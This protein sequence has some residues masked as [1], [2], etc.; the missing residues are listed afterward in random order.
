MGRPLKISKYALNAGVIPTTPPFTAANVA[1][2]QAY[3]PFS[4]LEDSVPPI[5][6]PATPWVGVVGGETG[7]NTSVNYPVVIVTANI[8]LPGGTG[9]GALPASVLRQKGARKY[10]V[11]DNA[12]TP[13][14]SFIVGAS[15]QIST[16]GTTTDWTAVGAGKYPALGDIFYCTAVGIGNGAAKLVGTCVLENSAAP[17]IGCMSISF[18]L[19]GV[20]QRLSKLTNKWL[21]N[22]IAGQV[23]GNAET[24]NVWEWDMI[25]QDTRYL[26]N[27]FNDVGY[28]IKSGTSGKANT[29]IEQNRVTLGDVTSQN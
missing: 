5:G 18:T 2:D 16:L 28:E 25:Q 24:G 29:A 9:T 3:P 23:G 26:A 1:V 7:P 27:F 14:L 12:A 19:G 8:A 4:A 15:Y 21:L 11:A 6:G 17:S 20:T 13:P 22:F 10:M